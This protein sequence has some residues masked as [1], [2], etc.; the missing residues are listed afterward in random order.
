MFFNNCIEKNQNRTHFEEGS[1][2]HTSLWNS[3]GY[4]N[5][6]IFGKVPNGRWPPYPAPQNGPYHWKSCS[7]ISYYLALV[8]PCIYSAISIIRN[9]QHNV[10]KMRR[11]GGGG[12]KAVWNLSEN[13]PELSLTL[14]WLVVSLLQS[15]SCFDFSQYNWNNMIENDPPSPPHPF[16]TFPKIIRFGSATLPLPGCG[17]KNAKP[18]FHKFRSS[19]LSHMKFHIAWIS[20]W[21]SLWFG[22][23]ILLDQF[24]RKN[25]S[26]S[27]Y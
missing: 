7:C 20:S 5:W 23:M 25:W 21:N 14:L 3:S 11:E 8:P 16:G 13:S 1:G 27:D 9:L 19:W 10:P 26:P 22:F 15:V 17:K 4:Q 24:W 6:W 2:S 18:H 12:S